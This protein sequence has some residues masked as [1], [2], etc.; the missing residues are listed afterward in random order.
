VTDVVLQL[1]VRAPTLIFLTGIVVCL[2]LMVR[3]ARPRAA[4]LPVLDE[5]PRRRP[6]PIDDIELAPW[7]RRPASCSPDGRLLPPAAAVSSTRTAGSCS[8]PAAA[9]SRP[10][11]SEESQWRE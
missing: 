3:G 10:G 8:G 7:P 4:R 5:P 2:V 11:M 9:E 1:A 6:R